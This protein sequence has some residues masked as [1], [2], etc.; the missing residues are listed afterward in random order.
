MC[1]QGR[2]GSGNEVV[3]DLNQDGKPDVVWPLEDRITVVLASGGCTFSP[4]RS[5][6]EVGHWGSW[7]AVA[8]PDGGTTGATS[9]SRSWAAMTARNDTGQK[10]R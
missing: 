4:R 10:D 6:G 7:L 9:P 3:A 5:P 8:A 1:R 2:P